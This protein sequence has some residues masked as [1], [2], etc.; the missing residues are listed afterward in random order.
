LQPFAKSFL[1]EA[2]PI[3]AIGYTST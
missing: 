2:H 3:K 1:G